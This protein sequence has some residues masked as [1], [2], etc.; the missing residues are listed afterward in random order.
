[1]PGTPVRVLFVS[2]GNACRSQMAE[3]WLRHLAPQGVVVRSGGTKPRHL[4][5]LATRAMQEAGV[6]IGSQRGKSVAAFA[7]ERFD[8]VVTLCETA[9]AECPPIPNAARRLHRPF[10]DPAILES[11]D[12]AGDLDEYRRL[13]DEVRA[14]VEEL[15]RGFGR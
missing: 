2:S 12:D 10:D 7:T 4:H 8:F 11:C 15:A 13:R 14:F 6:D 5:P 1:M 9:A 3:G